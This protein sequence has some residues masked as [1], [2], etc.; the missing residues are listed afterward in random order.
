MSCN[1]ALDC[2]N[3]NALYPFPVGPW[4]SRRILHTFSESIVIV[5]AVETSMPADP[6]VFP[7]NQLPRPAL[8]DGKVL[9]S[10]CNSL[11]A[12][13]PVSLSTKRLSVS[14]ACIAWQN[15]RIF[16]IGNSFPL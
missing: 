7:V 14:M 9:V 2:P 12:L 16:S 4:A 10:V 8:G 13:V 6:L 1:V 11:R 5:W 3:S 15:D